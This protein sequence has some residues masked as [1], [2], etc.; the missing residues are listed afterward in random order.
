M[1][2][3]QH[4]AKAKPPT[5]LRSVLHKAMAGPR[6]ARPHTILHA[7]DFSDPNFCPRKVCLLDA[8]GAPP[9]GEH[10]STA[11]TMTFAIGHAVQDLVVTFLA[12]AGVAVSDWKCRTCGALHPFRKRPSSCLQCSAPQWALQPIE[13]RIECPISGLSGGIDVLADMGGLR[14]VMVEVKTIRPEDFKKIEKPLLEHALRTK[15]Y[16]ELAARLPPEHRL[17]GRIETGFAKVFYVSKGGW[18]A[19]DTSLHAEGVIEKFSPFREFIV[20][21]SPELIAPILERAASITR[22]RR[23]EAGIPSIEGCDTVFCSRAKGCSMAHACFGGAFPAGWMLPEANQ[24][25]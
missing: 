2:F 24:C 16:L 12:N 1:K 7:S 19:L 8:T 18:G 4:L 15:I 23:R 25:L 21:P 10:L 14:P 5:T 9:K 22:F 11:Q 3:L 13:P 20:T 6:P 17:H